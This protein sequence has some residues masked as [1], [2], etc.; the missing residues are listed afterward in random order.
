V[1]LFA[2]ADAQD[3][4]GLVHLKEEGQTMAIIFQSKSTND[5]P[6]DAPAIRDPHTRADQHK[7]DAMNTGLLRQRAIQ[8]FLTWQSGLPHTNQQLRPSH[9]FANLATSGLAL[10]LGFLCCDQALQ[11]PWPW[12]GRCLRWSGF[13]G[14]GPSLTS[15][16]GHHPHQGPPND[17]QATNPQP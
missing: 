5:Y 6:A 2:W 13:S 11:G 3:D 7:R 17:E 9:P 12:W 8:R 1:P 14:Q 10:V 4:N 15:E 16:A